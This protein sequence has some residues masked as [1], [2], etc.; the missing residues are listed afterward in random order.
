MKIYKNV[1]SSKSRSKKEVHGNTGLP[2]KK[3]Y[4]NRLPLHIQ[5]LEKEEQTHPKLSRGKKIIN[6]RVETTERKNKMIT[7]KIKDNR[8]FEKIG[9]V[10]KP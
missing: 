3:K 2:K 9:K 10:D 1:G 8:F 7:E 5:E 4:L 6:L